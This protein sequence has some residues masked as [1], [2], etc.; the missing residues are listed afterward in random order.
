MSG[1][2]AGLASGLTT[3][4]GFLL[5][6]TIIVFIHEMGHF[7]VAR[8]CGVT[9]KTF[10][11]GFGRELWGWDDRYGTHWRVAAIPLGGYVKFIDDSNAA[12]ASD[13]DALKEMSTH[14]R[15]G[16]FQLK[17][18][19]QRAAVVAAGP[20]ANFI[21]AIAVY[22]G[23]NA[24]Y[25]VRLQPPVID[26]VV[27]GKPADKAGFKPGDRVVSVGGTSVETFDE[28]TEFIAMHGGRELDFV[29]DRNGAQLL[30]PVTPD[31][32]DI[33]NDLNLPMKIGDI[34]IRRQLAA[35]IGALQV[36]M[37]A[38][39]AGLM[40]GDLITAVD[41]QKIAN[42]EALGEKI[43]AS[44]GREV[45][46]SLERNGKPVEVSLTPVA[47]QETDSAGITKQVGRIG[48][49]PELPQPQAVNLVT[50]ARLGTKETWS[51]ITQTLSGI[52]EIFAGRQSAKQI[53][54]PILMAEVTGK[55]MQGGFE[56]VLQLLA[57]YSVS[58]GLLNLFP[59]PV[60]DGGHLLFYAIEAVR[61][62]PL[63]PAVQ[64]IAFRVGFAV[65]LTLI[66][67]A[68]YNDIVRT[69]KGLVAAGG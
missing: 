59:I 49:K 28:V 16:A 55:A 54:G 6:L 26:A 63:P 69:A 30:I 3:L 47:R 43:G 39:M 48:I 4:L 17:P 31:V 10:S 44:A 24:T 13:P 19:W 33:K 45:R 62:R 38:E 40:P 18:I 5:I 42:F 32:E 12:S 50:A 27:A 53:G 60:L 65:L 34:G 9:V 22:T 35:R 64:D 67:F 7:L 46:V 2:L 37:P 57:F 58:I 14:E 29:V 23:L 15:S 41:S 56:Y 52:G 11:I 36:G 51:K 25:G 68:N 61:R 20:L 1:L 66:V 8:W 21:L